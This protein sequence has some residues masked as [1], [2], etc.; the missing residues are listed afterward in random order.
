LENNTQR[1]DALTPII[2]SLN[3]ENISYYKNR[4]AY[5]DENIEWVVYSLMDHNIKPEIPQNDRV[6]IGLF[7]GPIIGLSTDIGY[8]FEDG[9]DSNNFSG[10]DLVLCGDIH[11]RQTFTLPEGGKAVMPGS[12]IQQNFGETVKHH[13][14]GIYNMETDG[15]VFHDLPNEQPF[16]HFE[17]KDITDIEDGKEVHLNL[18]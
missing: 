15:Y 9:F 5:E 12:L 4:G 16:L 10:L 13:G 1:L 8:K 3:N 17:I 2:D 11:K 14:Y 7:H 18:G 6:K